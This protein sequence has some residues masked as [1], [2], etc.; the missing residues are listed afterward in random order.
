MVDDDIITMLDYVK[1]FYLATLDRQTECGITPTS[2]RRRRSCL[3][4]VDDHGYRASALFEW[5]ARSRWPDSIV[6]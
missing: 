2:Y 6:V 1:V 4:A 3:W 5:G